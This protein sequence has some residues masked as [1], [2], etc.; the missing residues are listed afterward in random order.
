MHMFHRG[1]LDSLIKRTL[2]YHKYLVHNE[3]IEP[4]KQSLLSIVQAGVVFK[5]GS[6]FSHIV[7]LSYNFHTVHRHDSAARVRREMGA[8]KPL[9]SLFHY[10][11]NGKN[12]H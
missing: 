1:A 4:I 6:S 3:E 8:K 12:T 11:Q 5:A 7:E 2:F 9:Q 10:G